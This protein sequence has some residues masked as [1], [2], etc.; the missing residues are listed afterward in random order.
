VAAWA[1]RILVVGLLALVGL[2]WWEGQLMQVSGEV[3][4]V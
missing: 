1:V 3:A 2:Q 4:D